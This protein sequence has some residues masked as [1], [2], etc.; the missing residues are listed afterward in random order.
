MI[1]PCKDIHTH[2]MAM[3][4]DVLYV[5]ESHKIVGMDPELQTWRFGRRRSKARFV[6]ELPNGMIAH[7]GSLIYDQLVISIR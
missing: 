2:F 3:P 4:I 6:I 7:T 5:D 1:S